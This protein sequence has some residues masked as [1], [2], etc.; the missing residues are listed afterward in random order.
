MFFSKFL[1]V[2]NF[3]LEETLETLSFQ[4]STV[5]VFVTIRCAAALQQSHPS[6]M[7]KKDVPEGGAGGQRRGV[8]AEGPLPGAGR[9]VRTSLVPLDGRTDNRLGLLCACCCGVVV[10]E[11][12]LRDS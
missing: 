3:F 7:E 8:S 6:Q 1:L 11:T 9:Q 5:C 12:G 4:Y 10:L 2:L